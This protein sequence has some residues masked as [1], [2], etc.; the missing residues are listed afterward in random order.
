MCKG[1]ALRGGARAREG[2][3]PRGRVKGPQELLIPAGRQVSRINTD[4]IKALKLNMS[5]ND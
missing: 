2:R 4:Y 1:R 5:T 3:G